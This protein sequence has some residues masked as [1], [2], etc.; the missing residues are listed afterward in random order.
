MEISFTKA[1]AVGNDF[2]IVESA[3]LASAG[4]SDDDLP[5]FARNICHRHCGIGADGVEIVDSAATAEA[6]ASIR[7]FNSDGS[8]AEISGNGTRCVAAWLLDRGRPSPLRIATKAGVKA[9]RLIE[10]RG[11]TFDLEMSMGRPSYRPEEI[12]CVIDTPLGSHEV[13]IVDVGNPQ[14]ALLVDELEFDWRTLGREIEEH[15][16][17]PNR[18]NVSFVKVLGRHTI[19]VRF[20][21]RGAG[22]TASSGTG[23]TGAVAAAIL[24]RRAESPV[25]VVTPA[26][27]MRLRWDDEIVLEGPAQLIASGRYLGGEAG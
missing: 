17:F 21:E 10:R 14:C 8:E 11:M 22:E 13:T 18:T 15:P 4:L 5:G 19:E 16:R 25:T 7:L 1:Q 27:E 6:D 12:G 20:W 2:V 9:V 24:S 26:G 23:S 3:E